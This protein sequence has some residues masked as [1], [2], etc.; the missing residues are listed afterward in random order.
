VRLSFFDVRDQHV[1]LLLDL[2]H[3][4]HLDVEL[5]VDIIEGFI[6]MSSTL[7]L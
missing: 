2:R 6:T 1:N 5:R 3:P 7:S 4:F